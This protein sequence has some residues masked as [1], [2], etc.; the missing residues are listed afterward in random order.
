MRR[1]IASCAG[2][3]LLVLAGSP[4]GASDAA[5]GSVHAALTASGDTLIFKADFTSVPWIDAFLR[6]KK[7]AHTYGVK[8]E[9]GPVYW[10]QVHDAERGHTVLRV[11]YPAGMYSAGGVSFRSYLARTHDRLRLSYYVKFNPDFDFV[12]GGKLPGLYGGTMPSSGCS[13]MPDGAN[14]FSN[15]IMWEPNGEMTSYVYHPDQKQAC[16]D[17]FYWTENADPSGPRLKF[18]RGVW[19]HIEIDMGLNAVGKNDGFIHGYLNGRAGLI[20]TGMRFRTVEP[21]KID[22]MYF[23]TFFGGNEPANAPSKDEHSFFDDFSFVVPG[24]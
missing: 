17:A 2:V 8:P 3:S 24:Q 23:T 10:E 6:F 15:R 13:V 14:Y 11:V 7:D 5:R 9:K 20:K 12:K 16:G 4:T 22:S 1:L 19:N 18:Q 21:L